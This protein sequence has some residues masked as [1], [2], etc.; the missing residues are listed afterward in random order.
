MAP[1]TSYRLAARQQS[2]YVFQKLPDVCGPFGLNR[3]PP[4][5]F[6]QR[7]RNFPPRISEIVILASTASQDVG[8]FTKSKAALTGDGPPERITDV[9]TTTTMANDSRRA[10]L[11]MTDDMTSDTSPIGMALD[12]SSKSNVIRPLPGEE[13]DEPSGPLPALMILNHEGVLVAWWIVYSDS[14]RQR[15]NYPGLTAY[16]GQNPSQSQAQASIPAPAPAMGSAFGSASALGQ[17][18]FGQTSLGG[19]APTSTFGSASKHSAPA[20]GS[21]ST[22][23]ATSTAFGASSSL[24]NRSSPWASST[25]TPQTGAPSFGQPAFGSATPMGA[26]TS[27]LAF[28]SSAP[29]GQKP[30]LWGSPSGTTTAVPTGTAF[31]QSSSIGNQNSPFG[32]SAIPAGGSGSG[33]AS[34]AKTGGFAAVGAKAG[35]ESLF[36]QSTPSTSF[37]SAMDVGSSFGATPKKED[38]GGMFGASNSSSAQSGGIFG[39]PS[40]GFKLDSA[41]KNQN[42]EKASNSQPPEQSGNSLFG[43]DFGKSLGETSTA[44][45]P[46]ASEEAEMTTDMNDQEAPKS[47]DVSRGMETTTPADTPVPPKFS[48]VPPVSSGMFGTQAQSQV[49]P[50]K[51]QNSALAPSLFSKPAPEAAS[52]PPIIKQEPSEDGGD[53]PLPPDATSKA[54]FTPGTSSTS[55]TVASKTSSDDAPHPPDFLKPSA[56]PKPSAPTFDDAPLPPDFVKPKPKNMPA[57]PLGDDVVMPPDFLPSKTKTSTSKDKPE[58]Q[59]ALPDDDTEN[60]DEEGSGVDVGQ[61]VSS[62]SESPKFTPESSF[63]NKLD[64]SPVGERFTKIGRPQQQ[65]SKSLFGEVGL[66]GAPYFPPPSKVQQSP[67]SPSPVRSLMPGDMLRPENSRSVSAPGVPSR[68]GS[69][70]VTLGRPPQQSVDYKPQVSFEQRQREEQERLARQMEQQREEEEQSLS[71]QEDEWIQKELAAEIEPTLNLEQFIAHQ[72]YVGNVTKTG[73]AGQIEIVFRDINSMVDTLG[74]NCR[75]MQSFIKGNMESLSGNAKELSKRDSDASSWSMADVDWM[76]NH[77][78][79]LENELEAGRLQDVDEKIASCQE[80]FQ[81]IAKLRIKQS[82]VKRIIEAK[83]DPENIETLRNSPLSAEQSILRHDL[84][85]DFTTFQKSLAQA[86]EAISMLKVK[87]A[88]HTPPTSSKSKAPKTVPTV[89]AVERTIHKMTSMAEKKALDIDLL[90]SQMRT[91]SVFSPTSPDASSREN[92]PFVT[93][94]TSARK[95]ARATP[96]YPRTPGSSV[97]GNGFYTPGSGNGGFGNS[98]VSNGGSEFARAS[99]VRKRLGE[100]TREEVGRFGA[101]AAR[102][103]EVNGLL[104]EALFGGGEDRVRGMVEP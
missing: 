11:P 80:L 42:A 70:K 49:T 41:W 66:S 68:L 40:G 53:Q 27:T 54:T 56:K 22:L 61:E 10:Q 26:A 20:F 64:K 33:F 67:R 43:S 86:E 31:G 1:S 103:R 82:E 45:V 78:D 102:R 77:Q 91:L 87:L 71:D 36:K 60:F 63:G 3:S 104:R 15:T 50:A 57:T 95:S 75:T 2:T 90:E 37:N 93:P 28:G 7:L 16:A 100:V 47:P 99:P 23:G 65:S 34:F 18:A 32:A 94:P 101:K 35:G 21:A 88:S 38:S 62:T 24:G 46:A 74:L 55:S 96:I 29:L 5:Q 13:M 79:T 30:S 6:I 19:A 59:H 4:F 92:S 76:I 98:R 48:S 72:D 44:P 51:V 12:L 73:V 14:I 17:S 89:E 69:R 8:L 85:K 58:E 97:N 81:D 9:F 83:T 25:T 39:A 84:R 52:V